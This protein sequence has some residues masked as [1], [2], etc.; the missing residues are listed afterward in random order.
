MSGD[1]I[2]LGTAKIG[3][4]SYGFSS[5]SNHV[6][7]YDLF[8]KASE[9]GV[10]TLDT[11]PRYGNAE[12]LIGA[13]HKKNDRKFLISTKVDNL[14]PNDKDSESAIFNSVK[15][16]INKAGVSHIEELYLHQNEM[17]IISD[18]K[19]ISS[20]LKLKNIGMVKKIGVSIYNYEECKFSLESDVYDMVQI[21]I[22]IMDTNIYSRLVKNNTFS[23]K[24]IIARSV[25][26][27]GIMFNS[28]KANNKVS[29]I[30]EID[31]YMVSMKLL[32]K[33]Y[34]IDLP[35]LAFAFAYNMPSV[36]KVIVGTSST[37]NLDKIIKSTKIQLPSL[38]ISNI[39]IMS[40]EYKVWGN[41]RNW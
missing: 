22:N 19:I 25:F 29:H 27:Q 8:C 39:R 2:I 34:K 18:S 26:L 3:M 30:E 23:T 7:Y 1:R 20:L 9:L 4:P 11:S 38:L 32:S 17:D 16:S 35:S 33:K 28:K 12:E 6:S 10:L 36:S 15:N 40:D 24:E 31:E 5:E 21:P 14:I 37:D 41:P 13:Y